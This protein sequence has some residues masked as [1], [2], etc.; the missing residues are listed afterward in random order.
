LIRSAR[1]FADTGDTESGIWMRRAL[2][3]MNTNGSI[4]MVDNVDN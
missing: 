3:T 4:S 2:L 1:T